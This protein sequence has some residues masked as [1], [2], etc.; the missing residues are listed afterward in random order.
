MPYPNILYSVRTKIVAVVFVCGLMA[1]PALAQQLPLQA[2]KQFQEAIGHLRAQRYSLAEQ[3]LTQLER[4]FPEEANIREALAMTL[5]FQGKH[6]AATSHL[7]KVVELN[8]GSVPARQ[9]LAANYLRLGQMDG[10]ERELQEALRLEPGSPALH[11]DLGS[12]YLSQR[13]FKEALPHLQHAQ[14]QQ[15]I[16]FENSYKLAQCYFFLRQHEEAGKLLADLESGEEEGAEFL[17]LLGLNH[18][19]LGHDAAAKTTFDRAV[20]ALPSSPQAYETLGQM[21]FQLGFYAEAIPVFEFAFERHRDSYQIAYSLAEA[22]R[23]TGQLGEARAVAQTAL[24]KWPTADLHHLLGEV[25]GGLENYLEAI[26]HFQR[27]AELEPSEHNFYDL[28][29]EFLAHSSWDAAVAVFEKGLDLFPKSQRLWLAMAAAY[30]AQ[31]N[32]N[33]AIQAILEATTVAPDYLAAYRLL[34]TTYPV[35]RGYTDTVRQRLE[36]FQQRHPNDPWANYYYGLSLG[37]PPDRQPS[38]AELAKATRLLERAVALKPDLTGAYLQL[39][40]LLVQQRQWPEAVRALET[41]V[42]LEPNSVTAHYQLALAYRR[43]GHFAQAQAMLARY[44]SLKEQQAAAIN[45]RD[46]ERTKFIYSLKP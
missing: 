39:G 21:F 26:Q 13:K 1:S 3:L 17:I 15:R 42:R 36:Q 46:T 24:R 7:E 44:R 22:Y 20:S 11:S 2:I 43:M 38:E 34:V 29:Y 6:Q 4:E 19:A 35:S 16:G 12:L 14:Q 41:A 25:N 18:K 30:H 5:V 9:N 10:V 23:G 37:R 45:R 8:P 40:M 27:A 33:E 28:G 31:G 32:Y